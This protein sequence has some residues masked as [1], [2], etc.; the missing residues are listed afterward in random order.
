LT[1]GPAYGLNQTLLPVSQLYSAYTPEL[2]RL[3]ASFLLAS[4]IPYVLL[5][6]QDIDARYPLWSA[7]ATYD[8]LFANYS[9]I[10]FMDGFLLMRLHARSATTITSTVRA[11]MVGTWMSVPRCTGSSMTASFNMG[12]R[13]RGQLEG[14]LLRIPEVQAYM[15]VNG[16][17]AG[18]FRF[19][20]S[21]SG[22]G[23]LLSHY[24]LSGFGRQ[25]ATAAGVPVGSITSFRIQVPP[26]WFDQGPGTSLP[27]TFLCSSSAPN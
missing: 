6:Y 1:I 20:W 11:M 9:A 10:E 4:H 3:D 8:Y 19:V 24:A 15:R 23:L 13:T 26:G 16:S 22:D 17:V 21:V 2:D 25:S 5:Q 27:V 18:P 12:L 7:P 14:F